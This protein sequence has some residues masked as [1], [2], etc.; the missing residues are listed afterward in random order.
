MKVGKLEGFVDH[1]L[2]D[3]GADGDGDLMRSWRED[4]L[5]SLVEFGLNREDFTGSLRT[6]KGIAKN[7]QCA[8]K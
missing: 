7:R 1:A 8:L 5:Q 3:C 2:E 6:R 4:D